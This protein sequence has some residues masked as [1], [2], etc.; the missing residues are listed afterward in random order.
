M[1]LGELLRDSGMLNEA[2]CGHF[3][4]LVLCTESEEETILNCTTACPLL[5]Y[6]KDIVI[7]SFEPSRDKTDT[8]EVWLKDYAGQGQY[9]LR[10][11][12]QFDI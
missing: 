3:T 9:G 6:M 8:L 11:W 2:E 4:K 10:Q 5:Y 12:D 1:T 7:E